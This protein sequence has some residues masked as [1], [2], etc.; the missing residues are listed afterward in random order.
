MFLAIFPFFCSPQYVIFLCV[1]WEF[2]FSNVQYFV[3]LTVLA[4]KKARKNGSQNEP[5]PGITMPP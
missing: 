1:S 5:G 3:V 4:R 2:Q